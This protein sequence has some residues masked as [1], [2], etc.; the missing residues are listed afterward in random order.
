M[1]LKSG[2]TKKFFTITGFDTKPE[3]PIHSPGPNELKHKLPPGAVPVVHIH[4]HYKTLPIGN[5]SF[6][7]KYGLRH[8]G[9]DMEELLGNNYRWRNLNY[10]VLCNTGYLSKRFADNTP[11]PTNSSGGGKAGEIDE[12][13]GSNFYK[14]PP[15]LPPCPCFKIK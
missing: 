13:K 10:W 1:K 15:G 6:S 7:V 2:A 9:S 11:D 8:I 4:N 14:N 3:D 12:Y 5:Q